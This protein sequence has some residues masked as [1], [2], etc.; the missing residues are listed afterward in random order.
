MR[1]SEGTATTGDGWQLFIQSWLPDD[2]PKGVLAF[3]HGLAEHS[4]RWTHVGARLAA[5]GYGFHMADLRGHGK[6]PGKRGHIWAWQE[7]RQDMQAIMASAR[8]LA[9]DAPQFFGGH[10]LG[11]LIALDTAL[12]NPDNYRGIV[13]SA[14]WLLT[15][16]DVPGWLTTLAGILSKVAPGMTVTYPVE[17]SGLSHDPTIGPAYEDDPLVNSKIGPRLSTEIVVAQERTRQQAGRLKMPLYLMQGGADPITDPEASRAFYQDASSSDKTL[18]I[19][20]GLYHELLNE[21]ERD[22]ILAGIID[23]LDA[24]S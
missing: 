6:S 22:E 18:K 24:R 21:V 3:S 14:P 12:D 20:D 13:I 7:F 4:G 9:P 1:H 17:A 23:W 10:S 11:G 2:T 16:V 15:V 8:E 19:Y 5:A